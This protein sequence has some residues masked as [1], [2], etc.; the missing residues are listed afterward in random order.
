MKL[1]RRHPWSLTPQKAINLQQRLAAHSSAGLRGVCPLNMNEVKIVAGA[2]V[3][4]SKTNNTCYA[5][6]V[7]FSFPEFNIIEEKTSAR[8]AVFP[9]I[10]GLLS[11][12]EAPPLV[13]AFSRLRQKPDLLVLDA[14]GMAHPRRFGLATHLGYLYDMPSI[15]CAKT[16]L[17]GAHEQP[18]ARLG[19]W[20]YLTSKDEIIGCA[21]RSKNG[22]KPIYISPGYLMDVDW[23]LRFILRCLG[24]CRLPEITRRPHCFSNVLRMS[25]LSKPPFK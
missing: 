25:H 14:Q 2:D 12:R 21:L 11:F 15:G 16:R 13:A 23:A 8:K 19:D 5:A 22:C 10:P 17:T 3:S 20:T 4:Y 1:V 6:V 18:G 7:L 9:Y 24:R